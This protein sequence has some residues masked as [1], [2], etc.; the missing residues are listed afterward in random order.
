MKK[1]LF[2]VTE[3]FGFVSH[4]IPM[5]EAVCSCGFDVIVVAHENTSKDSVS[6]IKSLGF[7]FIPLQIKR[8]GTGPFDELLTT[9]RF[10]SILRKE[11]PD[12]L[13]NVAFKPII[14]GSSCAWVC[15]IPH[16][17]NL[18][19]G[20]G[21]FFIETTKLRTK[22]IRLV[23]KTLLRTILRLKNQFLIVQNSDDFSQFS[24]YVHN[25]HI[26]KIRGSGVDIG[27]FSPLP[28]PVNSKFTAT[29]MGRMIKD[30]GVLEFIEAAKILKNR[31][32]RML[33]VGS[34]DPENPSS[35]S[36]ETLT[37]L[38]QDDVIDWTPHTDDIIE[39]WKQSHAAV[40]PSYSEGSPKSLIE[41]AACQRALIATNVNGCKELI[42]H[43]VTGILIPPKDS[44]ALAAAIVRLAED[45]DLRSALASNAYNYV[46]ANYA[47]TMVKQQIANLVDVLL[48]TV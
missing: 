2:F 3:D 34:P 45:S 10:Y 44:G 19:A 21:S 18:I 7:R 46:K 32:I 8:G 41:A 33:L 23:I 16:I 39:V 1:A 17:I 40:L 22:L 31:N 15:R 5:A 26:R 38:V 30:K 47:S 42:E 25:G 6:T 20:T 29:F 28:E 36:K 11:K 43:N 24:G 35:I 13:F 37:T 4:R 48:T 9:I 27:K 14:Y 12:L